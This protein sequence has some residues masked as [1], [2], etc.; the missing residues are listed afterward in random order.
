VTRA[1]SIVIALF[2]LLGAAVAASAA[3]TRPPVTAVMIMN[4][5]AAPLDARRH[6]YDAGL[7]DPAP[8]AASDASAGEL[9]ADGSVRYGRT[10]VTVRNPCPPAEHLDLSRLGRR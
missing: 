9:L 1:G 7:K 8:V 3:E 6:S 10:I 4:I 5:V 2:A